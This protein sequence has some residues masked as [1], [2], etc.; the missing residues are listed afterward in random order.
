MKMNGSITFFTFIFVSEFLE[1][2]N[3]KRQ[4]INKIG[5]LPELFIRVDR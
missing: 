3:L 5:T 4:R 1:Y 2:K